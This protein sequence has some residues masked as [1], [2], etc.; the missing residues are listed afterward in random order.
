MPRLLAF[1]LLLCLSTLCTSA[2]GQEAGA[3]DPTIASTLDRLGYRYE[4][5]ADGD[6]LLKM[7]VPNSGGRTQHA[8]ILSHVSPLGSWR[9]RE[10]WSPAYDAGGDAFPATVANRLLEASHELKNGTWH[11]KD[12]LALL[13]IQIPA[14]ASAELFEYHLLS[15][16][17]IADSMERELLGESVDRY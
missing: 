14:D 3:A 17:S 10:I 9:I 6:Y 16:I 7:D 13:V 1:A 15:A 4:I 2:H 12:G 5:D 8:F 11:S